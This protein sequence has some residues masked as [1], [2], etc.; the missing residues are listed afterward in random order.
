MSAPHAPA[1]A[2][3][4]AAT[5]PHATLPAF[6]APHQH[7]P[8]QPFFAPQPAFGIVVDATARPKSADTPAVVFISDAAY[9]GLVGEAPAA[10]RGAFI[11]RVYATLAAQLLVTFSIVLAFTFSRELAAR[12]QAAPGVLAASAAGSLVFL[13]ALSCFP[14]VAKRYPGNVLC[15][16]AFT[17]CESVL[18]GSIAATYTTDS[19]VKALF[20]T[21]AMTAALTLYAWQTRVDFTA[22][23]GSLLCLLVGVLLF[24]FWTAAFPSQ[25]GQ[26]AYSV[27]IAFVFALFIV[28]DTQLIIGGS[29]HSHAFHTDEWVFAALNIYVDIIQL[30]LQLLRLF[31]RP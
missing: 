12:V 20:A 26:T 16:G 14:S 29:H 24:G 27:A 3:F 28:Y 11:R 1:V 4:D 10:T 30:F 6:Y 9:S 7:V 8:G 17:L 2:P 25:V 13:F 23:G 18:A 21:T 15:L 31:V 5:K 22:M 19:V